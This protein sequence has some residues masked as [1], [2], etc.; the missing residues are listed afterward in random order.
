M[1]ISLT[2]NRNGTQIEPKSIHGMLWLQTHF[3]NIHWEA[4]ASHSIFLDK[5]NAK[6]LVND[7]KQ[8]GL[9]IHSVQPA[10]TLNKI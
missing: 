9:I 8:A 10:I 2:E 4:I 3:E 7:A 1:D 6:I 5:S